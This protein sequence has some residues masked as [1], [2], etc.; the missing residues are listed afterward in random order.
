MWF[1]MLVLLVWLVGVHVAPSGCVVG[2]G[3][4]VCLGFPLSGCLSATVDGAFFAFFA[5]SPLLF[6]G[7]LFRWIGGLDWPCLALVLS[8][9]LVLVCG[10]FSL[11]LWWLFCFLL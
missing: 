8:V 1:C 6:Y 11:I 3:I 2:C 4:C 10:V 7:V 5:F 9:V